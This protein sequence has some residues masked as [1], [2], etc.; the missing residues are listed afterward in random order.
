MME[1]FKKFLRRGNLLYLLIALAL[2]I[3]VWLAVTKPIPFP[4]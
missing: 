4:F 2:A 3:L 1:Q